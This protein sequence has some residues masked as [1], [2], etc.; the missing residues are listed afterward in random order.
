[1]RQRGVKG[2]VGRDGK[3]AG[4]HRCHRPASGKVVLAAAIAAL[5]ATGAGWYDD[6]YAQCR[7]T[8]AATVQCLD[9]L[10]TQWQARLDRAYNDALAL[11]ETP[12]RE[13]RLREAQRLWTEYRAANCNF[14]REG[15]GTIAAIEAAECMRVLTARRALELED[16]GSDGDRP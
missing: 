2:P 12:E 10:T 14:Y 1:M 3:G 5:L 16:L 11:Q 4:D 7:G 8:T 15:Q 9:R 13:D 6:E